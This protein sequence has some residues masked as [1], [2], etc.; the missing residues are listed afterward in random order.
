MSAWETVSASDLQ[1]VLHYVMSTHI[2][3]TATI[4]SDTKL[5][6]LS[7]Y[8]YTAVTWRCLR[9]Y[10]ILWNMLIC[11][12]TAIKTLS[13]A[14]MNHSS[15]FVSLQKL[16]NCLNHIHLVFCCF[17]CL[18]F[19]S[20]RSSIYFFPKSL[21]MQHMLSTNVYISIDFVLVVDCP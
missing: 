20:N 17:I 4:K 16:S 6:L 7:F 13:K 1:R 14:V 5:W 9:T 21:S 15:L 11:W 18:M 3:F 8:S 19:S 10:I 2:L 12:D